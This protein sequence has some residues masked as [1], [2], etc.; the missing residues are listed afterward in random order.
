M[1]ASSIACTPLFLNA[2]PHSIGTISF[3]IVRSAQALLDLLDRTGR[4]P[5]R[6]LF[7]SSS[8]ASAALSTIFSRH[9]FASVDELGRDVAHL[10]LHALR[11][12]VPVDR[13]HADQVDHAFELFLGADRNLDRHRV[14]LEA[15]LHLVV[16]LE[17]VR[18][19]AVHLV[20]ERE[21]RHLVLVG[22]PPH[23]LRLRLHAAD[24]V[25]TP[26]TRRRARAS[27]ARLRS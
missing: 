10:V 6:Y 9:S 21:P 11:R 15:R 22:L 5:S 27:S 19:L 18:A 1:T 2:E 25:S 8:L 24:R 16:D 4:R 12:L 13:L 3:A 20:D 26:C 7:I 23:G 17:E 14:G